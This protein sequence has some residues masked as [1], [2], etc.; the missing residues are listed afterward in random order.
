MIARLHSGAFRN[1]YQCARCKSNPKLRDAWGC[2]TK[3]QMYEPT[4]E[5]IEGEKKMRY[6]MC[7]MK[8]IPESIMHFNKIYVYHKNYPSAPMPAYNDVSPRFLM[9][10]QYYDGK[11][12]EYVKEAVNG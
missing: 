3:T 10:S 6:W 5:E 8:F 4:F 7:P 11:Y 9:A 2:E 1:L 12:A